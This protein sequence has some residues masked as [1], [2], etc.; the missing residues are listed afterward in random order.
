MGYLD[1]DDPKYDPDNQHKMQ[2]TRYYDAWV[3]R[4]ISGGLIYLWAL[5]GG[6][7][8]CRATSRGS[9]MLIYLRTIRYTAANILEDFIRDL[10]SL[11]GRWLEPNSVLVMDNVSFHRS[12]SIKELCDEAVL[13]LRMHDIVR[14]KLTA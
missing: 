5:S 4:G 11:C 9:P 12:A 6:I 7:T 3:G 13:T 1:T 8:Q 2:A 10:L 14:S